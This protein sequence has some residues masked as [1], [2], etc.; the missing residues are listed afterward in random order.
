MA[1]PNTPEKIRFTNKL[2]GRIQ[3]L[4]EKQKISQE[5]LAYKSKL[6]PAYIS[7]LERGIY[8]PTLYV[9]WKIAKALDISLSELVKGI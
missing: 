5:E 4:R 1:K 7:H 8:S 2:S 9:T 6:N 3:K